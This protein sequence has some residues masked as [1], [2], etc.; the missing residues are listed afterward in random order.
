M[1]LDL[2]FYLFFNDDKINVNIPN[3]CPPVYV[4]TC[5]TYIFTLTSENVKIYPKKLNLKVGH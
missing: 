5:I 2:F 4:D 1:F 3:F